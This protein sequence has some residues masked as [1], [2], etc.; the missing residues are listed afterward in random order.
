[1]LGLPA[2]MVRQVDAALVT[3]LSCCMLLYVSCL[4]YKQLL[5]S[6]LFAATGAL[7][8]NFELAREREKGLDVILAPHRVGK[9]QSR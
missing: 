3:L 5:Q 2:L 8:G 6:R 1:M 7:L 9:C 4:V